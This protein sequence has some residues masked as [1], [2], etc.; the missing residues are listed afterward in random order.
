MLRGWCSQE[1]VARI[2][3]IS[4]IALCLMLA[5]PAV[6]AQPQ[7][8]IYQ[9]DG[10]HDPGAPPTEGG[11]FARQYDLCFFCRGIATMHGDRI[12]FAPNA[13]RRLSEVRAYVRNWGTGPT[14]LRMTLKVY[15]PDS[16]GAIAS[17]S[18]L[19][20]A[21]YYDPSVPVAEG[22]KYRFHEV[23]FFFDPPVVLPKDEIVYT[24]A[25]GADLDPPYVPDGSVNMKI[26]TAVW[27]SAVNLGMNRLITSS[28]GVPVNPGA[29]TASVGTNVNPNFNFTD[30]NNG[31]GKWNQP[32]TPGILR[33]GTAQEVNEK[34]EV[35][36]I[37]PI[38][39]FYAVR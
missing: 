24:I 5:S 27:N 34:P 19:A 1:G 38:V 28:T 33:E 25:V 12:A 35:K 22:P 10:K 17:A 8:V 29:L 39:T 13:P 31:P 6:L 4:W 23:R 16:S 37:S 15:V 30:N 9:L 32:W 7:K 36:G 26:N 18:P 21:Q 11:Y 3:R 14:P 20:S 2:M